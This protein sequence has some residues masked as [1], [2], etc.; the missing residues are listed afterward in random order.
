MWIL[1]LPLVP[2]AF[3]FQP[4]SPVS[5]EPW[6]TI[7]RNDLQMT[8]SIF[9]GDVFFDATQRQH[10]EPAEEQCE[11]CNQNFKG[12]S[13]VTFLAMFNFLDSLAH[14]SHF[15]GGGGGE[16]RSLKITGNYN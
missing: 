5:L 13:W 14:G 7:H 8:A 10:L 4:D 3:W 1:P 16:E 15:G 12:S 9:G 2:F 11:L 6:I